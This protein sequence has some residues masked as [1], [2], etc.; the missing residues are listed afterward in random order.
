MS[1]PTPQ[2]VG[3]QIRALL[4]SLKD[5]NQKAG[6]GSYATDDLRR[7]ALDY[8]GICWLAPGEMAPGCCCDWSVEKPQGPRERLV[9]R[10][11]ELQGKID[12]LC[13]KKS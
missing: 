1:L 7:E 6:W 2:S 4:L 13:S 12:S 3:A 9:F 10:L 11:E 5:P 8:A